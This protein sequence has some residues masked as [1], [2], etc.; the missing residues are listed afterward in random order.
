MKPSAARGPGSYQFDG[1]ALHRL[2]AWW[3]KRMLQPRSRL[4]EKMVLF[5]HDHFPSGASVLHRLDALA[6]Q[7]AMFRLHGLGQLPRRCCTR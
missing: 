5:W 6:E 4:L 2:Q 3:V 1:A 7:N